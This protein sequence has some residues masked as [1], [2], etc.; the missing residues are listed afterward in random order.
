MVYILISPFLVCLSTLVVID[1]AYVKRDGS[2]PS[3]VL[4]YAPLSYLHPDEQYWPA[5]IA[6]FLQHVTT[7]VDFEP[8]GGTPTL[9]NLSALADNVYL[10]AVGDVVN[11]YTEFFTSTAGEPTTGGF[12]AAPAT[13]IVVEKAGGIT[14]AFYFYFFSWNLGNV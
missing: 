9:Q 11:Y 5:D 8:F 1:A 6:T 2:F 14:D 7:Q 3:F 12:S 4:E 10:T 13:I